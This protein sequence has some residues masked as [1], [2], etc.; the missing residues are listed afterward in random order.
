MTTKI[1]HFGFRQIAS[2]EKARKVTDVFNSVAPKYDLM[3]DLMSFGMHR[4]WKYYALLLTGVRSGQRALDLACGTGDL[5]ARLADQVGPT[6][7][8][9]ACD[10]NSSM[11][12]LGRDRLTDRGIADN[13]R[14][15]Q[16]D[17]EHLPFPDRYFDCVTIAFGLRN[18]TEQKAVLASMFRVL[19]PGGRLVVLEFSQPRPWVKRAYDLYSFKALP[20]MGK[21]VTGDARSYR[22][23]AESIR[24]HPNQTALLAMMRRAGFERCDYYDL[25][26]GIVAVHRGYKL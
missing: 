14:Y 10:I 21:L 24:M 12:A 19:K 16:A 20:L 26:A 22:Y 18:V 6:G 8:V 2:A 5:T 4:L 17:A 3:N 23:L 1:T 7:E 11:L 15:V 25:S 9:W 13:V